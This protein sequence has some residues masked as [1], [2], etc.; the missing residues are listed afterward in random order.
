MSAP[1]GRSKDKGSVTQIN[2]VEGRQIGTGETPPQGT[3]AEENPQEKIHS[4]SKGTVDAPQVD[5]GKTGGQEQKAT[6]V[7]KPAPPPAINTDGIQA[8]VKTVD[9]IPPDYVKAETCWQT[10]DIMVLLGIVTAGYGLY[11][12]TTSYKPSIGGGGSAAKSPAKKKD[13]K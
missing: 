10:T 2:P 1:Q 3:E 7:N 8:K 9:G 11:K 12:L 6:E 5:Q 4:P 13:K